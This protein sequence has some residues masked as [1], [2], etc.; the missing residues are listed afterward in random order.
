MAPVAYGERPPNI[1]AAAF[2]VQVSLS[3]MRSMGEIPDH[4][5]LRTSAVDKTLITVTVGGLD[6]RFLF[7]DYT[8]PATEDTPVPAHRFT[9]KALRL[10][11]M[12]EDTAIAVTPRRAS[13]Q[14]WFPV[15]VWV[16]TEHE[17]QSIARLP[18]GVAEFDGGELR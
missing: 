2:A 18:E 8:P 17:W 14:H 9:R 15:M 13:G 6:N 1:L 5:V 12:I 16:Q 4:A 10:W 11:R 3:C 7:G